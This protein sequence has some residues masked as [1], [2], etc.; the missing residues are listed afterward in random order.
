KVYDTT[1]FQDALPD[2]S[3]DARQPGSADVR[4][5]IIQ[6]VL[7]CAVRH[8][9]IEYAPDVAPLVRPRIQLAIRIGASP[10]FTKAIIRVWVYNVMPVDRRQIATPLP[11]ILAPFDNHR[12]ES[13]LDQPQGSKQS[14][15]TT[16]HDDHAWRC[17]TVGICGHMTCWHIPGG[18]ENPTPDADQDVAPSRINGTLKGNDGNTPVGRQRKLFSQN[19][20]KRVAESLFRTQDELNGFHNK[21]VFI[22]HPEADPEGDLRSLQGRFTVLPGSDRRSASGAKVTERKSSYRNS[23]RNERC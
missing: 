14:C 7:R 12:S 22:L 2:G 8:K 21:K 13:Q 9:D 1:R 5:G 23:D 10:S 6:D 20:R 17:R 15:R 19:R 11:H 3:N 18:V 16:P 4:M